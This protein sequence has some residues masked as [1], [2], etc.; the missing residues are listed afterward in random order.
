MVKITKPFYSDNTYLS[1]GHKRFN[2]HISRYHKNIRVELSE[3]R[4]GK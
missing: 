1:E 3:T 4:G 2:N